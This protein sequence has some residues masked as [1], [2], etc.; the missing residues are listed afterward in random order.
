MCMTPVLRRFSRNFRLSFTA[1]ALYKCVGRMR[2][3]F[4]RLVNLVGES[5]SKSTELPWAELGSSSAKSLKVFHW[6]MGEFE[7]EILL[8]TPKDTYYLWSPDS[9]DSWY[10]VLCEPGVVRPRIILIRLRLEI[11]SW[12]SISMLSWLTELEAILLEN[13]YYSVLQLQNYFNYSSTIQ[14]NNFE[15][16]FWTFQIRI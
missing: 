9:M 3:S 14:C 10:S 5:W 15:N 11:K 6:Y 13:C 16:M 2:L 4:R 8:S 7:V 12:S 1:F